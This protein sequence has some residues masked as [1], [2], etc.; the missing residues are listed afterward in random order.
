MK[1]ER[2]V[3]IVVPQLPKQRSDPSTIR[4]PERGRNRA[5]ETAVITGYIVV[6]DVSSARRL[7]ACETAGWQPALPRRRNCVVHRQG[8]AWFFLG[9]TDAVETLSHDAAVEMSRQVLE[10]GSPLPLF[11]RA[12][13]DARS[14]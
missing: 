3:R 1:A 12:Q 2:I 5:L 14:A 4:W 8:F 11:V 6:G 9:R 13:K 7:A 10:C